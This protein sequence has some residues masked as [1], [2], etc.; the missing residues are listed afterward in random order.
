MKRILNKDISVKYYGY[1]GSFE[2][3][4]LSK[5]GYLIHQRYFGYGILE[6]KRHFKRVIG[7]VEA[8]SV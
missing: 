3:F 6:A 2:L 7:E 1:D 4:Y 5:T 8:A